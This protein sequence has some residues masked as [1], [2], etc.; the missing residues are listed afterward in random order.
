MRIDLHCHTIKTKQGDAETRNVTV[1]KFVETLSKHEVQIAAITNHNKFDLS[2]YEEFKSSA[3]EKDIEVWPGI[4]LD[5]K[6]NSEDGHMII[7][8]NPNDYVGFSEIINSLINNVKPDDFIIDFNELIE[9][10]KELDIIIIAH[11]RLKD[12]GFSDK[13]IDQIK[14]I[15]K[16][17]KPLMVEPP[18]LKTVGIMYANGI[19][20]FIGSDV[21]DWENYPVS[22]IPTLKMDIK[23]Y[24]TFKLLIRKD[25]NTIDT[26]INQK[27]KNEVVIQPFSEENDKEEIT[28]N[29]YNDVNIIFG[30]KGTGK[31][32][33]IE[34][35]NKYYKEKFG[36]IN[37]EYYPA[38]TKES[39]F[40]KL[41]KR[42]IKKEYFNKFNISDCKNEFKKIKSWQEVSLTPLKS[43]LKGHQS[44]KASKNFKDFGFRTTVFSDMVSSSK[45]DTLKNEYINI[46]KA[47]LNLLEQ[48]INKYITIEEMKTL[49]ELLSKIQNEA[50]EKMKEE[51]IKYKAL[52]F[53]KFT[54]DSMQ[55][56]AKTKTGN[57]SIPSSLGFSD[58][59]SNLFEI[60][61]CAKNIYDSFNLEKIQSNE[62]IG[63]IV[64]KGSIY[65]TMDFYLNPNV[66]TGVD[67]QK[68]KPGVTLLKQMYQDIENIYNKTFNE[69]INQYVRSFNDS[70]GDVC[71][72]LRDCFGIKTYTSKENN[73]IIEPY[74]PSSGE[75]CMLLL[76]NV[77]VNDNKNVYILDEPELSVGHKYINEIIVPRL[78]ELA[79]LDKIIIVSTHDA[80]IAVRTLPLMTIYREYK[81]T[82][83]GNLFID[84]LLEI[85]NADRIKWTDTSM[86]YLEGGD[87]A[88]KERGNSYGI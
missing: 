63:Y 24:D 53:E 39:D 78:K 61:L 31:S 41:I 29:I 17:E 49:K 64:E 9:Q 75:K 25:P 83:V 70:C 15:I 88:F 6:V 59:C 5:V 1:E 23:N 77:L 37:V 47:V 50:Y 4:E 67:Y 68:D 80:N 32:K 55:N 73:G 43:F 46:E 72:S 85:N 51:W 66:E 16:D 18:S 62:Y 35:L 84:E 13:S 48:K 58:F 81:K 34:A 38:Q 28:L 65:L 42:P 14:Q 21:S 3:F 8:C 33:I 44:K 12:H 87:F 26:F 74:N 27:E 60:H 30:G 52:E 19:N 7:I 11:H 36:T 2:Q 82:Y 56:I 76:H 22:K 69:N 71:S 20:G 79:A 45:Y 54:I 10:I 86:T 40:V 57:S